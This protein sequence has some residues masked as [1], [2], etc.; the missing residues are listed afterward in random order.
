[1]PTKLKVFRNKFWDAKK[2]KKTT[3]Q[4]EVSRQG[5]LI[6]DE[7]GVLGRADTQE[8]GGVFGIYYYTVGD[9]D[10]PHWLNSIGWSYTANKG[11]KRKRSLFKEKRVTVPGHQ[12]SGI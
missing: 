3:T 2:E 10:F 11:G 9:C 4:N 6:L 1:M 5:K 8:T 12:I 7:E